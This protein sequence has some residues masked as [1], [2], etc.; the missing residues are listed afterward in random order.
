M[1]KLRRVPLSCLGPKAIDQLRRQGFDVDTQLQREQKA[2]A[3]W[4]GLIHP[5]VVTRMHKYGVSAK[6]QRTLDGIVF[7]SKL[8]MHAYRLLQERGISFRRQVEFELSPAFQHEG[9]A[10]RSIRYVADFELRGAPDSPHLVDMKGMLTK[11]CRLKLKLMLAHGHVVHCLKS[12]GELLQ[13]LMDHAYPVRA[14]AQR[15]LLE[16]Q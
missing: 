16:N 15:S 4:L 7:D 8:E 3:R 9:R 12:A 13:F 11:E 6:D 2:R 14:S 5:D 10:V 1:S